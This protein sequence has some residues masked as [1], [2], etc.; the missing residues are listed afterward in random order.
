LLRLWL[1][2]TTRT[3]LAMKEV[4]PRMPAQAPI[5]LARA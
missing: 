5:R 3:A 4:D 2:V 1:R